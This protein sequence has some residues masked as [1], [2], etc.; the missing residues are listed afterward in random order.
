[1]NPVATLVST[2][3]ATIGQAQ[4]STY[5]TFS[6]VM[7]AGFYAQMPIIINNPNTNT[8]SAGAIVTIYRSGDT[9]TWE[10]ESSVAYVFARPTTALQIQSRVIALEPGVYIIAVMVGGGQASTWTV[11]LG[12]AWQI[13]AYA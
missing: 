5:V 10:S 12:T 3:V 9:I 6:F 4:Q 11:Q 8:L 7:T 13:T 2:Y 1:M